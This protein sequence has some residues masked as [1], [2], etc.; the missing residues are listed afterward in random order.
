MPEATHEAPRSKRHWVWVGVV[1]L[2]MLTAASGFVFKL[3]E[4]IKVVQTGDAEGFAVV[5][6]A[7]YFCVTAGFVCLFIWNYL[8]G[9][10][11]DVERPKYDMLERHEEIDRHDLAAAGPPDR[12]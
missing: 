8:R 2:G 10:F 4:F 11:H 6:V 5:P 1:A 3:A 12:T 9:G 7:T